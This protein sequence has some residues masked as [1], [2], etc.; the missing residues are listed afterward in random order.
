M[1]TE[2]NEAWLVSSSIQVVILGPV[3]TSGPSKQV[4]PSV[5]CQERFSNT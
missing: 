4:K 1:N 3:F 5:I 2:V